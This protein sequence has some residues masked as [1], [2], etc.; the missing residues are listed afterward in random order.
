MEAVEVEEAAV[1][2]MAARQVVART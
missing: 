2:A 1:E